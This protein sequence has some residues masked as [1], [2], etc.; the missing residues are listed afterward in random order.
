MMPLVVPLGRW[1]IDLYS[2]IRRSGN[3]ASRVGVFRVSSGTA[4]GNL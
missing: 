4:L 1:F 3:N 2:T